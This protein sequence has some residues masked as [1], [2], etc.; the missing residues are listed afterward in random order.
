MPADITCHLIPFLTW[1]LSS[2]A[3]CG[4]WRSMC[5]L[6]GTPACRTGASFQTSTK[7]LQATLDNGGS[8]MRQQPHEHAVT[9]PHCL[10][11][12]TYLLHR[13]RSC[14]GCLPSLL[15]ARAATI[16]YCLLLAAGA[17]ALPLPAARTVMP[18]RYHRT[19]LTFQQ[20][21]RHSAC[22]RGACLVAPA[23]SL[24]CSCCG[25]S[26]RAARHGAG[27]ATMDGLWWGSAGIDLVF[28][29][30]GAS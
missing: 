16:D 13:R 18:A 22:A 8:S 14:A 3:Y 12:S 23:R 29:V 25:G 10:V 28:S 27:G 6:P 5:I 15:A 21:L 9:A 1:R 26:S 20:L 19:A 7:G 11:S 17:T 24:A 4:T 2:E 30:T